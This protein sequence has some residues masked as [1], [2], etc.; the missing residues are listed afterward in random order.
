ML[1]ATFSAGELAHGKRVL[2]QQGVPAHLAALL[3]EN[4]VALFGAAPSYCAAVE[5]ATRA[6]MIVAAL[7]EARRELAARGTV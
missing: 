6:L 5:A 3:D 1:R 2:A 4:E 7:G